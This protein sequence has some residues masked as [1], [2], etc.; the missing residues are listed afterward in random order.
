MIHELIHWS[1]CKCRKSAGRAAA[2]GGAER[3]RGR[4]TGALSD[5][6]LRHTRAF[7]VWL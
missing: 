3:R 1:S 6:R 7:K 5:V 2:N 4:A